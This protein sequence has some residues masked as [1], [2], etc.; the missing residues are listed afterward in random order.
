MKKREH[1]SKIICQMLVNVTS[2]KPLV[3]ISPN[4]QI[5]CSW[6]QRY[7][8]QTSRWKGQ[9]SRSQRDKLRTYKLVGRFFLTYLWDNGRYFLTYLWNIWTYFYETCHSYSLP[10]PHDVN[11][12]LRFEF[13]WSQIIFS[14]MHFPAESYQSMVCYWRLSDSD[15]I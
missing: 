8:D 7:S 15:S 13:S 1:A 6:G 2:Y 12:I 4:L 5:W 9:S 14:K 10:S 11:D 3:G